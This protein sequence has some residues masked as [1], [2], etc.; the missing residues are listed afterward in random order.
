MLTSPAEALGDPRYE[1]LATP[2]ASTVVTVL[3]GLAVTG[4]LYGARQS[5]LIVSTGDRSMMRNKARRAAD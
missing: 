5:R 1:H 3:S 4:Q 2:T